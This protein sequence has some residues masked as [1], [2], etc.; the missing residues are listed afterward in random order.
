MYVLEVSWFWIEYG[1]FYIILYFFTSFLSYI[2]LYP[3]FE[4]KLL[5]GPS[6]T[7]SAKAR[8]PKK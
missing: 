3:L 4:N 6:H 7:C 2:P 5:C 8:L 1:K